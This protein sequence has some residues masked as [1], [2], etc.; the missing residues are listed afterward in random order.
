MNQRDIENINSL[1]II[2]Q[3]II[4]DLQRGNIEGVRSALTK[5]RANLVEQGFPESRLRETDDALAL[6]DSKP[7]ELLTRSQQVVDVAAKLRAQSTTAGSRAGIKSFAPIT[8]VNSK[9]KEKRLVSPSINRTT[10]EA[11][12]TPF[13]IPEGFE[14]SRETA[15]EKRAA[16]VVAKV[17]TQEKVGD[18]K[19]E[20]DVEKAS[21][22]ETAKLKSQFKLKPKVEGAVRK[23]LLD[24]QVGGEIAKKDRSNA[25]ALAVYD[26]AMSG[27]VSALGGTETGPFVGLTPAVTSNQQIADGAVAAMAP[28]LKQMFRA[29]GEGIFSDRDQELLLRMVPTRTDRKASIQSKLSN[30]DAIVRVKLAPVQIGQPPGQPGTGQQPG[31]Q[32]KFLGFE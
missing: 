7:G 19:L 27:L 2:A 21:R 1:D 14:V 22:T 6:L 23:A 32:P 15:E 11:E 26:V 12:L 25:R 28:V 3:Q 30:I 4:P 16:D 10:G 5:R 8:L 18:V 13:D 17:T 29:S 24:V 31:Q 9:T 20:Q